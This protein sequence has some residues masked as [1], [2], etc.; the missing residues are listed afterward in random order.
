MRKIF[1][2][3]VF[4]LSVVG[5]SFAATTYTATNTDEHAISLTS[6]TASYENTEVYKTG[7]GSS[8][9]S[10]ETYDWYGGNAAILATGGTLTLKQAFISSDATYGS[11][12]FSHG[13]STKVII[14]ESSIE[15]GK[16][17]SGGIMVAGGGTISADNL[18]VT[19]SAGSSAAIRSDSQAGGTI[20]VNGGT[21]EANGSGSPAIYSTADITVSNATLKSG[22]AQGIVI[23]GGNSVTLTSC[24]LQANNT[25][26]NSD[27]DTTYQGVMI[28][29]SNSGDASD[30]GAAFTMTNGKITN[31]NGDVFCVTNTTCTIN[32]TNVSITNNGS[33]YFLR[34]EEQSWGTAGSNGGNVTLNA[35]NQTIT[36][37]IAIGSTSSLTMSL[38]DNSTFTGTF[39]ISS[40]A[41]VSSFNAST[42]DGTIHV[43]VEDGS[44]VV[45]TGNSSIT[46]LT[47]AN[48]SDITYGSYTLNVNGTSYTASNPASGTV[49]DTSGGSTNNQTQNQNQNQTNNN[50]TTS[51][52][53]SHSGCNG[54][55]ISIALLAC[56]ALLKKV[57]DIIRTQ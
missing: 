45:L 34:A 12:V 18:Y 29:Q 2:A 26:L 46:S 54:G 14:S 1:F 48:A 5:V 13:S 7:D 10:S 47:V 49:G 43:T 9:K 23:E 16:R 41:S 35:S 27:K 15:T 17:N 40:S 52:G 8:S 57:C 44:K 51:T 56:V 38:K 50:T 20:T 4:V 21:Y 55:Y 30:G 37:N 31:A 22:V 53:S 6:G 11:A 24:D 36:G 25:K 19:T 33:G 3:F 42:S 28:Y 39:S 32:L